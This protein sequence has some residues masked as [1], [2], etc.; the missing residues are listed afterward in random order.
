MQSTASQFLVTYEVVVTLVNG[1][2]QRVITLSIVYSY[3]CLHYTSDALRTEYATERENQWLAGMSTSFQCKLGVGPRDSI[4]SLKLFLRIATTKAALLQRLIHLL[5]VCF[6]S[7]PR[8]GASSI[9]RQFYS[10]KMH[11]EQTASYVWVT[12]RQEPASATGQETPFK[13]KPHNLIA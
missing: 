11:D 1:R 6:F 4:H 12:Y 10:R 3:A 2:R 8:N 5:A 7:T 9:C 13:C